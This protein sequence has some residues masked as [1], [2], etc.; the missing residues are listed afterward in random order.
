M[1]INERV[2]ALEASMAVAQASLGELSDSIGRAKLQMATMMARIASCETGSTRKA[3]AATQPADDF[4]LDGQYGNPRIRYPL[5]PRYWPTPDTNVG[6]TWSEC[7]PDYLRAVVKYLQTYA[8]ML[9]KDGD[10]TKAGYK[11]RDAA[12][13]EGW[14]RRI[15][16]GWT[17]P[18]APTPSDEDR[19]FGGNSYGGSSFTSD[20]GSP[21]PEDDIPFIANMTLF[22][23]W[24][25]P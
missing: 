20:F 17:P 12:R 4:E 1:N 3:D 15:E 8:R 21:N 25:K 14:A 19:A 6:K 13:A 16:N 10:E 5:K 11:E 9:R 2:A 23:G 7:T 18:P 24:A 22:G